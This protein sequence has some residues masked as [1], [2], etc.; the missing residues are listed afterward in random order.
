MK[1]LWTSQT[2]WQKQ[3]RKAQRLRLQYFLLPALL[4]IVIFMIY[5]V[6]DTFVTS[7][8]KW[9]GISA[10]S[11]ICRTL[12]TGKNSL[13]R[14]VLSGHS[15]QPQRYRNSIFSILLQIPLGLLLATFLDAGGRKFNIFKIVWFF[16]YLM[17]SVAI[18]FLFNY[19]L[20]TNGGLFSSI[21]DTVF[22]S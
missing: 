17:S 8:Y 20:A 21:A 3:E 6:I 16:P 19:I 12:T 18:A 1:R 11:D 15:F 10:G 9:N 4:L 14:C 13:D 7:T 5:P 22:R 2:V